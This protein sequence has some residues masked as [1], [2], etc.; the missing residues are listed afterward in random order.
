MFPRACIVR[1]EQIEL[2][3]E[4]EIDVEMVVSSLL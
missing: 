4:N 3:T 1:Y 2:N